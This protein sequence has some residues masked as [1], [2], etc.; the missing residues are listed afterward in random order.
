MWT[1]LL[2]GALLV[3]APQQADTTFAVDP[4]A[5]LRMEDLRG[6]LVIRTWDRPEMRVHISDAEEGFHPRVAAGAATVSLWVEREGRRTTSGTDL[7]LTIPA[8]M[9]VALTGP[10][11]DVQIDGVQGEISVESAH[12]D[13]Q[14]RGGSG[15]VQLH[16][17]QGD[18]GLSG[19]RG[20]V[21]VNA[22]SGDLQL[23]DIVGDI[24]AETMSGD[25]SLEKVD[26]ATV[27]ASSVSGD[28]T[29]DGT[30]KEGGRYSL[31]THSG[32]VTFGMPQG[33]GATISVSTFTGDF[34]AEIP[35]QLTEQS[36]GRR[37]SFTLG[38]GS[39]R[40]ELESFS[41]DIRLARAGAVKR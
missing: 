8:T 35:V 2:A 1:T 40:V 17:M 27:R 23:S 12:G 9:S 6:D 26:A 22:A 33:A 29:Y 36:K 25:V 3:A 38:S 30:V 16:T 28:V 32:D 20:R 15:L 13:I 7:E 37:F 14:V 5:R 10:G 11:G 31:S 24:V 34:D 39:A 18:I 19:A 4:K 41:G 21:E